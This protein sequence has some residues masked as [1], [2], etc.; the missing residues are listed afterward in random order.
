VAVGG[1]G[2][3]VA[4]KNCKLYQKFKFSLSLCGGSLRSAN[5]PTAIVFLSFHFFFFLP[6]L[7][8]FFANEAFPYSILTGAFLSK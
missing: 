4:R 8:L 6:S 5:R 3:K 2:G 7:Y 1:G